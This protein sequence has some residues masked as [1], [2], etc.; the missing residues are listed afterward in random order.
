[1][2]KYCDASSET[3]PCRVPC[4]DNEGC[5]CLL[6][7]EEDVCYCACLDTGANVN[8]NIRVSTGDDTRNVPIDKFKPKFKTS[9][10]TRLNVCVSNFPSTA[11]AQILDKIL[12]NRILVPANK[13]NRKVTLRLKNRTFSQVIKRSGLILSIPA[14]GPVKKSK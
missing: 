6:N 9:E 14:E 5:M 4:E 2:V 7:Q 11:F 13:L 1:M 3:H 8:E 12:P 10:K